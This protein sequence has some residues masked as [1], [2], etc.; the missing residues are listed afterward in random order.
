M[1]RRSSKDCGFDVGGVDI[2]FDFR[3]GNC[4]WA[5]AARPAAFAVCSL[6]K[7]GRYHLSACP[8]DVLI[9]WSCIS[10]WSLTHGNVSG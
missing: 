7:K 8:C 9:R 1:M 3:E 4:C 10:T 5:G 6:E 2:C